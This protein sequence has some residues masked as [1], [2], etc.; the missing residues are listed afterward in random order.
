[1]MIVFVVVIGSILTGALVGVNRATAPVIQRN[2]EL[3]LKRNVLAAL[4]IPA[5]ET[6]ADV[7]T[8][9]AA[10]VEAH[11]SGGMTFYTSRDTGDVAF[12]YTGPGLWGPINGAIAVKD[13]FTRIRGLTV[14]HQEE[15]PGLGSRITEPA[16]LAQFRDKSF[17]SG[18]ELVP[19]GRSTGD[20]QIDAITGATMT[21]AAFVDLLNENLA[22]AARAYGGNP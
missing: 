16:Y 6:D 17:R 12:Q 18:L 7:E 5:G 20:T 13:E 19:P 21:A 14:F 3:R 15:T 9:F 4:E 2:E 11:T 8:A 22:A 1:M 10:G